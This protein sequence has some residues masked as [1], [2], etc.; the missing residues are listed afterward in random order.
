MVKHNMGSTDILTDPVA[1][2][3]AIRLR[4]IK[5]G[6]PG[7]TRVKNGHGI[8]YTDEQ[9]RKITDDG[10]LD[11]IR[12]LVLPP[13]WEQVWICPYENGHLQATGKD[14]MG[15][16]QYRY[17][18]AWMQ[19]RN[20]TKYDRLLHF[21]EKLPR[22]RKQIRAALR[23]KKLDKE[24]VT[25]LALSVMEAT[26]I[27]VGNSAYEK[28]YGSHGI[29]TLRSQHVTINGSSAFFRFRGKKGILHKIQLRHASLARLLQK[30]KE[31][32]GQELFQYYEGDEHRSLDSG[33]INEYLRTCTGE[34]FTSKDIR[35]WAG[36]VHALN[37]LADLVPFASITEC[38][39]NIVNIIDGVAGKLGN[40]R[41]VCKKYYIHPQL[42]EA[43]EAGKLEPSLQEV[44]DA[45]ERPPK[46][47]LHND[48]KVLLAFLGKTG[49]NNR[50]P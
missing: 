28:L 30:V 45:R 2:A 50:K 41:A 12:R 23:K 19:A 11:R 43:Y 47:A 42:L 22:I 9:G 17:H 29:T 32:P 34:D 27:R 37:L 14:A 40:T 44:R 36:T 48:E 1:A 3:R 20:E 49:K 10:I 16:K 26:L 13:A 39:R 33:D 4:Y 24:K 38:K 46:G 15:R 21:G 5:A 6:T 18:T 7:Y 8:G 35:T 31:I 25:A